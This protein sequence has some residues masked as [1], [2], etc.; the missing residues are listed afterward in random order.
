[1]ERWGV[2]ISGLLCLIENEDKVTVFHLCDKIDLEATIFLHAIF[3]SFIWN[4]RDFFQGL[5]GKRES[6][7][8]N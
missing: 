4:Q 3:I 7:V 6:D 5:L 8:K 1:M 2:V